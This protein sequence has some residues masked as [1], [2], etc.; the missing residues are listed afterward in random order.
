MIELIMS[1]CLL[2]NPEKCKVERLI[3]DQVTIKQCQSHAQ[4]IMSQWVGEHPGW[5]IR[6]Y[7]CEESGRFAKM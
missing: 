3:F 4:F 7:H 6:K 1:L 2:D 5:E